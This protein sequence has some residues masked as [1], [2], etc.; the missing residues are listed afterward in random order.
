MYFTQ[1]R[2][3]NYDNRIDCWSL[4]NLISCVSLVHKQF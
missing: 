1:L 4:G 3:N 2:N